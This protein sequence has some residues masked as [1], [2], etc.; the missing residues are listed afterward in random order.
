MN[1][2]DK[3]IR[4]GAKEIFTKHEQRIGFANKQSE[5][6]FG[7]KTPKQSITK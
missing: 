5:S 2:L 3:L 7:K 4:N 1:S 6:W